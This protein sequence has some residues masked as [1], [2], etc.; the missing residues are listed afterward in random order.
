MRKIMRSTYDRM[1]TREEYENYKPGTTE[2]FLHTAELLMRTQLAEEGGK[3]LKEG[4]GVIVR[5]EIT[6]YSNKGDDDGQ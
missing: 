4:D 2:Y 3:R 1:C 6:S 5:L